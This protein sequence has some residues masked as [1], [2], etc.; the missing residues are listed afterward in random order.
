MNPLPSKEF[1]V[2][3]LNTFSYTAFYDTEIVKSTQGMNITY[4]LTIDYE[5]LTEM[6]K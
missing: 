5:W 2:V 4:E 1:H 3:Y 6:N